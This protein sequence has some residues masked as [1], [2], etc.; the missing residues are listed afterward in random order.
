MTL[1]I[2]F[3]FA[4]FAILFE[5]GR[6][7]RR[8][9]LDTGVGYGPVHIRSKWADQA[10]LYLPAG[11]NFHVQPL[12]LSTLV[13]VSPAGAW[14]AFRH[15][16]REWSFGRALKMGVGVLYASQLARME[17]AFKPLARAGYQDIHIRLRAFL[18]ADSITIPEPEETLHDEPGPSIPF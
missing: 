6:Q 10:E 8:E 15:V 3:L 2:P 5:L 9:A 18:R 4:I 14:Q 16:S 7:G 12:A 13:P 11:G 17:Q 1:A